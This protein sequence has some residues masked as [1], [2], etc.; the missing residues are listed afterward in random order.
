MAT[1]ET[2]MR[3]A[4]IKPVVEIGA[5]D[6]LDIRVGT[7]LDVG[8]IEGSRTLMRLRVDFGDHQRTILAGLKNE[9][10]NPNEIIGRQ[11]LF[12]V[13]LEPKRMMG[14]VSEGMLIDVGYP[15]GI[16]PVLTIPEE[17]VPDG[18]RAG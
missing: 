17:R 18:T 1:N 6:K 13:N 12:L 16:Q 3:P 10:E 8:E 14:L 7:I 5:F 9:R 11:T 15:D 4:A 2:E